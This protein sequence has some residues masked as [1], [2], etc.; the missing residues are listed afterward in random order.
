M[1]NGIADIDGVPKEVLRAFSRRRAEIEAELL[2]RGE[3]SAAAARMA[4]LSTRQRKDYGVVPE[5]LVGEWREREPARLGFDREALRVGARTPTRS[6]VRRSRTGSERSRRLAAPTGLTHRRSTFAPRDVVQALCEAV[7]G[8][9]ERRVAEFEAAA[10]EFLGSDGVRFRCSTATRARRRRRSVCAT[11]GWCGRGRIDASRRR[12]CW[13]SSEHVIETA[14]AGIG[15]RA[16]IVAPTRCA[17]G[18]LAAGRSWPR[19]RQRWSAGSSRDGD[20][21]AIV[22]GPAGT[23]K[24]VALAAAREAWEGER[25][26]RS[27][28][29]ASRV[30]PRAS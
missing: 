9:G 14:V 8:R 4:T 17:D 1:R 13:R 27:R 7:A 6:G 26:L 23:G 15:A 2:R 25:V 21:V 12:S 5:Q 16:A 24:T 22:V 18:A 11:G 20:R 3:S 10:E 28:R 19:S 30:A 29:G